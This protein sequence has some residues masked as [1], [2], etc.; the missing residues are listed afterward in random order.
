MS[1]ILG[2][3]RLNKW[4]ECS[5]TLFRSKILRL[6]STRRLNV[7]SPWVNSARAAGGGSYLPQC[8]VRPLVLGDIE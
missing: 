4:A 8:G 6:L 2:M 1:I 7:R 5:T 3:V